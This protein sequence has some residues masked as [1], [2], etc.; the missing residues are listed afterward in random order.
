VHWNKGASYSENMYSEIETIIDG[1]KPHVLG[2]LEA[3][4]RE[5]HDQANVQFPEY[6]LHTALTLNNQELQ[7]SIVVVYTHK[8]LVVKRREDLEEDNISAI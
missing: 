1:H 2:L 4:L 5:Q 6:Q 7:V 8:S 3:N